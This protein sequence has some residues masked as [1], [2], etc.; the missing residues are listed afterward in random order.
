M[1]LTTFL[2]NK[3]QAGYRLFRGEQLNAMAN[4]INQLGVQGNPANGALTTVG[5][6]TITA[7]LLAGSI[8][9]RSG[10]SANFTD[11]TDTG[12]ALDTVLAQAAITGTSWQVTYFNNTAFTATIAGGTGVTASGVLSIPAASVGFFLLTRTGTATY[13]LAGLQADSGVFAGNSVV[14]TADN[15]GTQ[16]LT[17]AMITGGAITYHFSTGGSTPSLTL[18]LGTAMD[19][20]MPNI[21]PGQSYTLRIINTNSGTATIVTNT[22]WTT[23]GTLTITGG[24]APAGGW[25]DF[26]VTKTAAGTYTLVS[27]GIGTI[28]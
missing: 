13:S 2:S 3:L 10:P 6:G 25:R 24:T 28:S 4:A 19:T 26:V 21:L 17:A 14:A 11:T 18:P 22:G 1:A 15:G 27:V 20:A 9:Q 16:T 7:A 23:T 12:T 5:A 8:I